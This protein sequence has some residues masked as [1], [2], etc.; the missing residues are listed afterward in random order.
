MT[1]R[2]FRRPARVALFAF[3]ACFVHAQARAAWRT[4]GD[5]KSFARQANG[6]TLKLSSGAVVE[7]TFEGADVVRVRLAPAGTFERDFSYARASTERQPVAAFVREV[8]R[9]QIEITSQGSETKVVVNRRPFLVSVFDAKGQL[10]VA[11]DP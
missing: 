6:A 10:I 9:D 1:T 5:V 4:A 7:V 3:L 11:D 2:I 8:G